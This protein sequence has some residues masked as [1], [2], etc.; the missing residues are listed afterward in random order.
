MVEETQEHVVPNTRDLIRIVDDDPTICESFCY[1]MTAEGWAASSYSSAEEFLQNDD[2]LRPGCL[3]LDVQLDGM[4]G[5]TLQQELTELS[6]D[7]PIIFV[8]AYG[9]IEMAVGA[10]L[11]GACDFIPKP[12]DENKLL[13]A[14]GRAVAK[15]RLLRHEKMQL[16][17]SAENWESLTPREKDVAKLIAQ[18]LPNKLVADRLSV[19][20]NTVQVH[21]AKIY[22]KLGCKSAAEIT[23][24]LHLL[25]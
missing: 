17:A 1:L 5:L 19:S 22:H 12:V 15:C 4:S 18:G 25:S 8:S 21:R 6:S 16:R 23:S 14:V 10:V 3:V 2:R 13:A 20:I 9:S 11:R 7:L 24:L